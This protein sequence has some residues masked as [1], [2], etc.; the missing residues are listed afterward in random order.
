MMPYNK[1]IHNKIWMMIRN[2]SN[3]SQKHKNTSCRRVCLNFIN[4]LSIRL[5]IAENQHIRYIHKENN[6]IV[7]KI[8][9]RYQIP[10]VCH[11][12]NLIAE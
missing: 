7:W 1:S 5:H 12:H 3:H 9:I 10:I 11:S 4:F 8:T 6:K 2:P